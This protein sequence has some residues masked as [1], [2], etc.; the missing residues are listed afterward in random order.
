MTMR[1]RKRVV[2]SHSRDNGNCKVELSSVESSSHT[3]QSHQTVSFLTSA[4]LFTVV[5]YLGFRFAYYLKQLHEN[6]MFFSAIQV[7]LLAAAVAACW[8][9]C[10]NWHTY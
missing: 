8:F 4:A 2:Q 1:Q 5:L 3:Q 10:A 7:N 6:E 9:N